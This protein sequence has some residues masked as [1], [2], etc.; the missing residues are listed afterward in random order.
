MVWVEKPGESS[1]EQRLEYY[2]F[3][4]ISPGEQDRLF[5]VEGV[6]GARVVWR[7]GRGSLLKCFLGETSFLCLTKND[8]SWPVIVFLCARKHEIA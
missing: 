3:T 7:K 5:A 8:Y 6:L 4:R 1:R 2:S